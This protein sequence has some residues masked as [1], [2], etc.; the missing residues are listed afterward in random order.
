MSTSSRSVLRKRDLQVSSKFC[1]QVNDTPNCREIVFAQNNY[2]CK[3]GH[4]PSYAE[5]E[6]VSIY[7]YPQQPTVGQMPTPSLD[8]T[9]EVEKDIAEI[10]NFVIDEKFVFKTRMIEKGGPADRAKGWKLSAEEMM[11]LSMLDDIDVIYNLSRNPNTIE[12]ALENIVNKRNLPIDV[13]LN[14]ASHRNLNYKLIRVMFA[15]S[16]SSAKVLQAL[17]RRPTCPDD[18]LLEALQTIN[19]QDVLETVVENKSFQTIVT[20]YEKGAKIYK[21]NEAIAERLCELRQN[22]DFW[23]ASPVETRMKLLIMLVQCVLGT[24]Q[25]NLNKRYVMQ[26]RDEITRLF[27]DPRYSEYINFLYS[28]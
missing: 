24:I 6:R 10:Q 21:L 12:E 13:W 19:N 25:I 3:K 2:Y 20:I 26:K 7:N 4:S 15:S 14:I 18:V 1:F 5:P 17:L 16:K 28:I 27:N 22:P 8:S 11:E 9:S 23:V